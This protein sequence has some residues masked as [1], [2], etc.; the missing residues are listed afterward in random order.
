MN[1]TVQVDENEAIRV[2]EEIIETQPP[3]TITFA[4][5]G[6]ATMTEEVLG[7]Y[8]GT[9]LSPTRVAISVDGSR[10]VDVELSKEASLRLETVDV[11]V[12]TPNADD[13]MPNSDS[14]SAV[15]DDS[16]DLGHSAPGAIAFTVEGIIR[17][18]PE[19]TIDSI[20]G[21][22]SEIEAVTFAV[23]PSA[24]SDGGLGDDVVVEFTLLG[25]GISIRRD[26]TID[27]ET[28]GGPTGIGPL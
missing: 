26:G 22:A 3:D 14:F 1:V 23:E 4:A 21:R 28:S 8:E 16:P 24:R 27:V 9:S 25:F 10:S 17:G 20:S 6:T 11:G 13:L 18:V 12:E 15:T 5:S 19:G 2:T 7:T